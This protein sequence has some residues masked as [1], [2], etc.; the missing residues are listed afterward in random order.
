[1]KA[2]RS[3]SS[4]AVVYDDYR[5]NFVVC[6]GREGQ[7]QKFVRQNFGGIMH[8]LKAT[9]SSNSE[10][11][12]TWSCFDTLRWL[13]ADL[14]GVALSNLW[15]LAFEDEPMPPGFA[16]A[17]IHIGKSYGRSPNRT[18][19][20]ASIEDNSVLVFVEAKLY[21]AMSLA[22]DKKPHD[23]LARKIRIGLQ[24]AHLSDR[25]FYLIVLDIAPHEQLRGL[26]PGAS[27]ADA[28]SS[29]GGGFRRKW[30]TA[31]W[32]SRY[33]G[34]SSVSPLQSVLEGIDGANPRQMARHMGWLTWAD[35]FK[36]V[37]RVSVVEIA[38]TQAL[39]RGTQDSP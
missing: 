32:F 4:G 12:L 1:M 35:V 14:R 36:A 27:L 5:S 6:P 16:T 22:D 19:V 8:K 37:L 28:N 33:K 29:K 9:R 3:R 26:K 23:Q 39:A 31:Y 7:L 20:D 13:P 11:A 34:K 17:E 38:R 24:E 15:E 2:T 30:L 25:A 18:E 10:D 21:S